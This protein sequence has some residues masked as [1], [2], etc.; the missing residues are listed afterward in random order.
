MMSLAVDISHGDPNNPRPSSASD[1][2]A[3][4]EGQPEDLIITKRHWSA[5]GCTDLEAILHG[6]VEFKKVLT[7]N[8]GSVLSK[9]ARTAK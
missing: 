1:L 8:P 6:M 9:D 7:L 4:S 5:F 3:K 2:D